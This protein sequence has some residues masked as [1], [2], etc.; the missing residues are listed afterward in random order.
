ME[1]LFFSTE[2]HSI[3]FHLCKQ[4]NYNLDYGIVC[5]NLFFSEYSSYCIIMLEWFT[6]NVSNPVFL[7]C[8]TFNEML[9]FAGTRCFDIRRSNM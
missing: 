1:I 9:A 6:C 4:I 3:T 5:S 8:E 2:T 7:A